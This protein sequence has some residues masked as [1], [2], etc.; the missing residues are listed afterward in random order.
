MKKLN[1]FNFFFKNFIYKL[2]NNFYKNKYFYGS[3]LR[4][5]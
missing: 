4:F 2:I 1:S 5:V 3:V